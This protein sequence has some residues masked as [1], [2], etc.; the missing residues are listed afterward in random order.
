MA[1]EL[2]K[3]PKPEAGQYQNKRKLYLIPLLY[4]WQ[5]APAEYNLKFDIYWQQVSEHIASLESKMGK[6]N[7]IYH[8][9][10]SVAGDEGLK[11]LEKINP[12]SAKIAGEKCRSGAQIEAV[13]DGELVEESMDWERHLMLGFISQKVAQTVSEFFNEASKKRY[14]YI[15]KKIDET[16]KDNEAALLFIRDNHR[17]QFPSDIEV[18]SVVP[19]ML[20]EIQRWFRDQQAKEAP[21]GADK[22]EETEDK[23]EEKKE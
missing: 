20:D 4:S 2:G 6:V 5:D 14:E 9:S 11:I 22:A 3:I 17:V 18:F 16:F 23:A 7:R 10:I 19:P 15:A 21:D 13:E 12:S 1:E 8:E